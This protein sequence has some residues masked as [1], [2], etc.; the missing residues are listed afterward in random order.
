VAALR[1]ITFANLPDTGLLLDATPF[2]ALSFPEGESLHHK[3]AAPAAA[4][5]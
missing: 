3:P 4:K 5:A 2:T 1:T